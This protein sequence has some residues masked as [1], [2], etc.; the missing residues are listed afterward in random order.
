MV[1]ALAGA[2]VFCTDLEG[3][4]TDLATIYTFIMTKTNGS[5]KLKLTSQRDLLLLSMTLK[6]V[7]VGFMTTLTGNGVISMIP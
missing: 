6:N 1:G 3:S 4:R 5:Q 7:S 2:Y